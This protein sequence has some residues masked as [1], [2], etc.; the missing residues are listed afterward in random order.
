V[1]TSVNF[2]KEEDSEDIWLNKEYLVQLNLTGDC[3]LDCEFC[4][5][6]L[7]RKEYLSLEKIKILWSNLRKYAKD[8]KIEYR[9]NLTGG[10]IFQHPDWR[11]IAGF[12]AAE[13][14]ITSVDPLINRFWT[15]EHLELLGVLKEKI[16]FVQLNSDVVS[17]EDIIAVRNIHKKVVLK[18]ALY[19]GQTKKK[20]KKLK[21]LSDEFNNV[22]ISIDLI[23]P[24]KCCFGKKEDYLIFNL[25]ELKQEVENLKN[26]FGN[27][28]WLLSTTIKREFLKEIYYCPVPFGGVYVM[29]NSKIVPCSRYS[30]LETGFDID[31]FDLLDYVTRYN[32]LCS[33]F[34]LFENKFFDEFWNDKDNPIIF[35][36][37]KNEKS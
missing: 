1:G 18:I 33:N 9:V 11:D 5:M 6:K 32:K 2:Y 26:I 22:I 31:N 28:L 13:E 21:K 24:Q 25:P 7:Y 8:Y 20:I 34:C 4:Y 29:P 30:H 23:I 17:K 3:P 27:K 12:I 37:G 35:A 15:E 19:K 36:G 14:T 16:N 10:D